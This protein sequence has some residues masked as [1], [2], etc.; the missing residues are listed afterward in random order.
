LK[1]TGMTEKP[2]FKTR[3]DAKLDVATMPIKRPYAPKWVLVS[4]MQSSV[5]RLQ[6][7]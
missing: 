6:W 3:G 5:H 7:C 2:V 1:S 4:L